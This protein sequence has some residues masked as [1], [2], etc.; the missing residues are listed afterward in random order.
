LDV[1]QYCNV[2]FVINIVK[3]EEKEGF[4]NPD[5][6]EKR[7]EMDMV[8]KRIENIILKNKNTKAEQL[9]LKNNEQLEKNINTEQFEDNH[10]SEEIET[11]DENKENEIEKEDIKGNIT[12]E[13]DIVNYE[14]F[15]KFQKNQKNMPVVCKRCF[16]LEKYGKMINCTIK[17]EDFL[18]KLIQLKE[19]KCLIVSLIN[20]IRF[21]LLIY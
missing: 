17:A 12:I 3:F 20:N 18:N 10:R 14:D 7:I 19:R 1:D 6:F 5:V 9:N 4:V 2:K 21:L 15:K 8:S 16:N 11:E 13:E